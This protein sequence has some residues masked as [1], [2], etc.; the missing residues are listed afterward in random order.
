MSAQTYTV[1][2]IETSCDETAAAVV[3]GRTVLSNVMHSQTVHRTYGGVVPELASRA[4]LRAIAP[5]VRQALTDAGLSIRQIDALAVTTQP[6]LIGSLLVGVN[7]AK[8][9]ALRTRLPVVPVNHIEG[10]IFSGLLEDPALEFPFLALVVSGG[11]TALFWVEDF[12]RLT[13][14]GSTRDDAAGEAF[15]KIASL[16]GL[17]YPGG[18]AID[19]LAAQGNPRAYTFPRALLTEPTFDFSFS[20]LKTAVRG[21]LQRTFPEGVPADALPDLC[22]SVQAAIVDVLVHKTIHAARRY[23][24]RTIVVAGGVSAN[25]E[26]RRRMQEAAQRI[27][28]RVVLPR[29]SYCLD[30]AAMIGLVAHEKLRFHG[31]AAYR[32]LTFIAIPTPLRSPHGRKPSPAAAETTASTVGVQP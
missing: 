7:F 2:A 13:L 19:R 25:S 26:L 4:H 31:P 16:L 24:A 12:Q 8:G 29:L 30:N 6:G 23:R 18:P 28:A 15:D 22:A 10:H 17:G 5:V 27:G 20:G 32:Q 1:L 11:H 21:M 14:L 9:L 3:R